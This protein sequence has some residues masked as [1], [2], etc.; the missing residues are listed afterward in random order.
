MNPSHAENEKALTG[1]E[2]GADFGNEF[3]ASLKGIIS[4]DKKLEAEGHTS[5]GQVNQSMFISL[6]YH[7][8]TECAR[9]V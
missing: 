9:Q 4:R 5:R 6:F 8:F 3:M 2:G 1:W 7:I